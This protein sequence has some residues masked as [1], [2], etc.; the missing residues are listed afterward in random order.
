MD[1]TRVTA[2]I[3]GKEIPVEIID[4]K[5]KFQGS[6]YQ[7]A[8]NK[9]QTYKPFF[10]KQALVPFIMG[11]AVLVGLIVLSLTLFIWALPVIVPLMLVFLIVKGYRNSRSI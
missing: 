11:G 7:R 1:K 4:N 8:E 6:S 3:D 5:D 10:H 2:E 9:S